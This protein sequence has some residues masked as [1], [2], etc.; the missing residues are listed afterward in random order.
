MLDTLRM[1]ERTSSI[2]IDSRICIVQVFSICTKIIEIS[3]T[4]I[5]IFYLPNYDSRLDDKPWH[6]QCSVKLVHIH[7]LHENCRFHNIYSLHYG[8]RGPT[9]KSIWIPTIL[10]RANILTL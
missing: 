6:A 2:W 3:M 10:C 1:C 7:L 5:K 9:P 8:T 4:N